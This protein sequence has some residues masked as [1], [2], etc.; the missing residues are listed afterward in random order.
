VVFTCAGPRPRLRPLG[1]AFRASG[2]SYKRYL[3]RSVN[4]LPAVARD[5][6]LP[7]GLRKSLGGGSFRAIQGLA[8]RPDDKTAG[9]K[10]FARFAVRLHDGRFPSLLKL[11]NNALLLELHERGKISAAGLVQ[12]F[13]RGGANKTQPGD[14]S[15][16]RLARDPARNPGTDESDQD[17]AQYGQYEFFSPAHSRVLP[18]RRG[19]GT[20]RSSRKKT[21]RGEGWLQIEMQQSRHPNEDKVYRNNE[22]E[23]FRHDED[24]DACDQRN[25]GLKR[26]V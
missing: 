18:L 26:E 25:E 22:V 2:G 12:V 8:Q 19:I 15:H 1:V 10:G 21:V 4:L 23:Q 24:E 9:K 13:F 20:R 16:S 17:G 14:A 11:K 3:D 6:A 5:L 7:G